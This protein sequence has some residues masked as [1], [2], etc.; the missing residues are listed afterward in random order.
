MN[1]T[2][3]VDSLGPRLSG[4]GRYTWELAQRLPQQQGI[5]SVQYC[6]NGRVIDDLEALVRGGQHSARLPRP[7]W[8]TRRLRRRR[9]KSTLASTLVHGTNYFLPRE[10][11]TGIITVHDLSVLRYPETHPVERVQAFERDFRSSLE[12]SA[13]IITDTQTVRGEVIATLG[14]G[15]DRVSAIPLGVGSEFRPRPPAEISPTL[16][17]WGLAPGGY[18]LCVSAL[19]PRKRI[20]ELL[21]AWSRLPASERS[22]T[23]LVLVGGEG[24]LNEAIHRQIADAVEA[25]W[26]RHL[27]FVD[28]AAL[29]LL[30]A[31]ARLFAYPS[32]YEGFGLPPVEA[33]ASGVPV[34]VANRSCLPEV[35]GEAAAYVDPDDDS[36]FTAAI[37]HALDDSGW[38]EAARQAGLQ[39]AAEL[40]WEACAARTAA[41]YARMN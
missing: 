40:S 1:V 34:L 10:A 4:I 29:P 36:A 32:V 6:S 11:A 28:D 12:R 8:L 39:R 27:G 20:P 19:E 41:V 5:D 25:G 14:V 13:H 35:C 3:V 16:A 7:R 37:E 17:G 30:Y 15:P 33:M 38:R 26:L 31:G 9:L 18:G 21:R 22:A 23:P 2:L 24:W